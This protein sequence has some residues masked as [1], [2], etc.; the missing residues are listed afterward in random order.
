[1]GWCILSLIC[2]G[3]GMLGMYVRMDVLKK[4]LENADARIARLEDMESKRHGF[5]KAME[6]TDLNTLKLR[7]KPDPKC[8]KC[9]GK[10][11]IGRNTETG[12]WI[13]CICCG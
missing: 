1:M 7:C 8:R 2:Y 10:G 12:R 3:I 6:E 11:T 5:D 4:R 9:R 13:A